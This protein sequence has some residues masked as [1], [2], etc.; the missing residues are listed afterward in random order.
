VYFRTTTSESTTTLQTFQYQG[1]LFLLTATVTNGTYE[2]VAGTH[3]SY[4]N[5]NVYSNAYEVIPYEGNFTVN[6][7]PAWINVTPTQEP[8]YT[9]QF[10]ETGL[11]AGG[12]FTVDMNNTI[13][14][15][16]WGNVTSSYNGGNGPSGF[17]PDYFAIYNGTYQYRVLPYAGY[18]PSPASGI[19]TVDGSNIDISVVFTSGPQKL[20]N[21]TI[22]E[23][24]LTAGLAWSAVFGGEFASTTSPSMVFSEPNG[25]YGLSVTSSS[26]FTATAPSEVTVSGA[27]VT[28]TVDFT[29][30]SSG[31]YAVT[32]METGLPSGTYWEMTLNGAEKST[33]ISSVQFI[34]QNGTYD[35]SVQSPIQVNGLNYTASPVSG[36]VTVNGQSKTI[37]ITYGT[38]STTKST[39]GSEYKVT[40]LESDLP[41]GSEWYVNFNG[42]VGSSFNNSI[43]FYAP[44]GNYSYAISGPNGY[45]AEVSMGSITVS[46]NAAVSVIFSQPNFGGGGVIVRTVQQN[47]WIIIGLTV[48][49]IVVGWA[50]SVFLNPESKYNKKKGRGSA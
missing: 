22:K 38:V 25:T 45:V 17:L 35:Y 8:R 48:L 26:L 29:M 31:Q 49:S 32:F 43:V 14:G 41:T 2:W 46:K 36:S 13:L 28:V 4:D 34:E 50:L 23:V 10:T 11:P 1:N 3:G 40:F 7:G 21:V 18:S 20:Y 39:S 47:W 15:M 9:V 44:A 6:G 37:D 5:S 12:V 42:V 30:L 33:D 27:S 24:G 16:P 19:I